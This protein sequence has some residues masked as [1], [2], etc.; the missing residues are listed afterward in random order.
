METN[1]KLEL[2]G[3]DLGFNGESQT[4]KALDE[5]LS[6]TAPPSEF[7]KAVKEH[8]NA[9]MTE[10][11]KTAGFGLGTAVSVIFALWGSMKI[12]DTFTT[13]RDCRHNRW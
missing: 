11:C 9:F 10:F 5:F 6:T 12:L 13:E 3:N 8:T 1:N 4:S 7:K 2:V